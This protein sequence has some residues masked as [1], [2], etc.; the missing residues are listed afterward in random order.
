MKTVDLN[1]CDA[2][3]TALQCPDN[4]FYVYAPKLPRMYST[5]R[6][7][8]RSNLAIGVALI[9]LMVAVSIIAIRAPSQ[10]TRLLTTT[11]PAFSSMSTSTVL[12]SHPTVS[13]DGHGQQPVHNVQVSQGSFSHYGEPYL[14]V[15]PTNPQNLLGAAQDINASSWPTPGTFVSLDGGMSWQ[16]SGALP[17]PPG[18]VGGGDVTVAFSS[19]GVGFV[20]SNAG[21]NWQV[22]SVLVWR[23][24]NGGR[25]FSQPVEVSH[26]RTKQVDHPW[27]AID[28]ANDSR[29]GT[30]YV[31]WT[32]DDP[33]TYPIHSS[34]LLSRSTDNGTTFDSPRVIVNTT[35]NTFP[36][37]AVLNIGGDGSVNVFYSVVNGTH[38]PFEPPFSPAAA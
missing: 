11:V 33:Q 31:V 17:L 12:S 23:T 27:M 10:T 9:F 25:S 38:D 3:I 4:R 8:S 21:P 35:G 37:L 19:Q 7:I 28:T 1:I 24:E 18:E 6:A 22:N 36:A 34:L 2:D 15:D 26:D 32:A 20:A 16:D 14:A 30:V 13:S 5:K 29:R